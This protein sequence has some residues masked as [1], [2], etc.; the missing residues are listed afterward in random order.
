MVQDVFGAG[1][2]F[3]LCARLVGFLLP[4]RYLVKVSDTVGRIYFQFGQPT[5]VPTLFSSFT[6]GPNDRFPYGLP[7]DPD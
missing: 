4:F 5:G 6:I 3:Q 1:T 2:K 7:V